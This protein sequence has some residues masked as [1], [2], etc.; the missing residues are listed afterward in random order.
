MNEAERTHLYIDGYRFLLHPSQDVEELKRRIVL[1]V[2]TQSTF[3]HVYS[4]DESASVLVTPRS[5]VVFTIDHA[6]LAVPE[7]MPETSHD[8][9]Y[10]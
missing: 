5:K 2:T 1:A 8:D 4:E 3:V 7:E 10:T 6:R 9:W